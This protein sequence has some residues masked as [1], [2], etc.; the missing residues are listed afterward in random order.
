M[1]IIG[2]QHSVLEALKV[3]VS[4]GPIS[5]QLHVANFTGL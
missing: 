2:I 1:C 5:L 4:D 3:G